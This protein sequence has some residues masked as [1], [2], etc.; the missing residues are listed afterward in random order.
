[1]RWQPLVLVLMCGAVACD[2]HGSAKLQKEPA[3]REEGAP[4]PTKPP[5]SGPNATAVITQRQ[6]LEMQV[7]I[8]RLGQ[9]TL[10]EP[11]EL[12]SASVIHNAIHL[13]FKRWQPP[14]KLSEDR[15]RLAELA[16]WLVTS[17][18]VP[19]WVTELHLDVVEP[20]ADTPRRSGRK[21]VSRIALSS[22]SMPCTMAGIE[23]STPVWP[24]GNAPPPSRLPLSVARQE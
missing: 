15:A 9:L 3:G 18:E 2:V 19:S 10:L 14:T 20:D 4:D 7:E 13:S 16:C 11:G 21:T 17:V 1:M 12:V 5:A 23:W 6:W 24:G 8:Q 22:V